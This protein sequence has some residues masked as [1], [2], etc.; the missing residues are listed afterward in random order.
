MG[1]R[2][3][4]GSYADVVEAVWTGGDQRFD[5]PR[6]KKVALKIV[7]K[8]LLLRHGAVA[9]AHAERATLDALRG[10]PGI[11]ELL[12]TFQDADSLYFGTTL[13]PNGELLAQIQA[14]AS[15][16]KVGLDESRAKG[17]AAEIVDILTSLRAAGVAHRDVKPENLL[18]DDRG[19]L[20][21]VDF[22][23]AAWAPGRG[24]PAPAET[25]LPP[26]SRHPLARRPAS[27]MPGTAD[28]VPPEALAGGSGGSEDSGS[29]GGDA[30]AAPPRS[31]RHSFAA[32]VWAL[33]CVIFQMLT[34]QP[35]FR[36]GSEYL[37][38]QKISSGD[39]CWPPACPASPAARS[40]V[41]ACLH[42]DPGKRLGSADVASL[43]AH[44]WFAGVDWACIRD[45]DAPFTPP[46]PPPPDDVD[47][48]L[49]S[50][51]VAAAGPL[52]YEHDGGG[53]GAT[54]GGGLHAVSATSAAAIGAMAPDTGGEEGE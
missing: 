41:A 16:R 23:C 32:D 49:A 35:P 29:D 20:V 5:A 1:R 43:R 44:E 40:F 3:G 36:G 38:F 31:S 18:L 24:P 14:G 7:D 9:A 48:G 26:S 33:G 37:T 42:P 52:V 11:V 13:I 10:T 19:H 17:Y 45:A 30:P 54:L 22:G 39:Y 34:G 53:G 51:T 12:F 25:T 21:L 15:T 47:W 27:Q 28:Y 46:P 4:S 6:E 50:L 2:L 8:H